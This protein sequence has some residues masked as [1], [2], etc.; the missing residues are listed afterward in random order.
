MHRLSSAVKS[1]RESLLDLFTYIEL[2]SSPKER[3]ISEL[4][5]PGAAQHI[6]QTPRELRLCFRKAAGGTH[7]RL[8]SFAAAS[9]AVFYYT[10]SEISDMFLLYLQESQE[11]YVTIYTSKCFRAASISSEDH[12]IKL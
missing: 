12:D 7:L 8:Y 5:N 1:N 9:A 3:N 6:L 10:E 4:K 2:S 11:Q